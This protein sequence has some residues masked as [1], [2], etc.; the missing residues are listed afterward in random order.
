[1]IY[2]ALVINVG[3]FTWLVFLLMLSPYILLWYIVVKKRMLNHLKLLLENKPRKWDIEKS[4]E[5]YLKL[6]KKKDEEK[7]K[8]T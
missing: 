7:Q 5:E 8:K 1:M 3:F 4:L 6:I 2:V